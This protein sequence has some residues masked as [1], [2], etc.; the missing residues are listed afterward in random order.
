MLA[1]I[2]RVIEQATVPKGEAPLAVYAFKAIIVAPRGNDLQGQRGGGL[3]NKRLA[4]DHITVVDA[5]RMELVSAAAEAGCAGICLFM[6][7]MAV[8]PQ[9]P[10]FDVYGDAAQRRALR[11]HLAASGATLDLAYP[12]TIAGRTD[13]CE[14]EPALICAAELGAKLVNGLIYDRDEERR[15]DKLGRFGDLAEKHGLGVALG[16]FIRCR[17]AVRW[18]KRWNWCRRLIGQVVWETM[19][20]SCI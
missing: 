3:Q 20:I 16:F 12:F 5:G 18:P 17:N 15:L 2:T 9:M 7:P 8:L 14:L 6:E 19:P 10:L 13:V 1:E 11:A 4:L